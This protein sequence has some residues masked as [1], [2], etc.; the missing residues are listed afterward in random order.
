MKKI[1]I[2][3]PVIILLIGTTVMAQEAD[4]SGVTKESTKKTY[5]LYKDGKLIKNAVLIETA[6]NHTIAF[7]SQ[8]ENKIDSDRIPTPAVVVKTVK[9]D[10][11]A[12]DN[13]DEVIKFSY[14]TNKKTD[15]TLVSSEKDLLLAVEDGKNIK[16]LENMT[17]SKDDN[18]SPDKIHVFTLDDGNE[19]QMKLESFDEMNIKESK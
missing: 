1:K 16:V 4:P 11:D 13:Y 9:I 3:I 14:T 18:S 19:V 8:D 5:N 2:I 6:R 15:F 12:D 7:D 10:N 17:I